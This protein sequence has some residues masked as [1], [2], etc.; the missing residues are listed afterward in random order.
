MGKYFLKNDQVGSIKN[1]F[2]L[3]HFTI[4]HYETLLVF[5]SQEKINHCE[6][7][8]EDHRI[9]LIMYCIWKKF[10]WLD[11]DVNS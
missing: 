3:S 8:H 6:I 2:T 4:K 5:Y 7:T 10:L 9:L 11:F 1:N